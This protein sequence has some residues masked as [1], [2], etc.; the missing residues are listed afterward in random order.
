MF[1][2]LSSVLAGDYTTPS[3]TLTPTAPTHTPTPTFTSTPTPTSISTPKWNCASCGLSNNP[4]NE[5][6]GGFIGKANGYG[7]GASN[8]V[9]TTIDPPLP[10]PPSTSGKI[11]PPVSPPAKSL[12]KWAC[13]F[14][15]WQNKPYN[16]ICGGIANSSNFDLSTTNNNSNSNNNNKKY[17]CGRSKDGGNPLPPLQRPVP[18]PPTSPPP[19]PPP[20]LDWVCSCGWKNLSTNIVCGG[21]DTTFGCDKTRV[22]AVIQNGSSLTQT[23]TTTLPTN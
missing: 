14:C 17:G 5:I 16:I 19:L 1:R 2:L 12:E 21:R 8:L 13:V 18:P 20:L 6:C 9:C 22:D 4:R 10:R 11:N 23:T 15:N 7:C 3:P